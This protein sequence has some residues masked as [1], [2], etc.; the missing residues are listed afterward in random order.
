VFISDRDYE[1]YLKNLESLS[2]ELD[3]RV[4]SYCLM[5]NHVHL[6]VEPVQSGTTLSRMMKVLAA[7][8]TRYVNRLE[9]RTGT[10]WEG[11]FK[12]SIVDSE[13]Y[14]LACMR[15]IDLNPVKAAMVKDPGNY[16]WSSYRVIVCQQALTFLSIHPQ[17]EGLGRGGTDWRNAYEDFVAAGTADSEIEL[18]RTAVARNQLT[19]S[20]RFRDQIARRTGRRIE[21][22]GRGRPK[23]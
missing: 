18:I 21:S 19:G 9:R 20:D 6:L 13:R 22:R 23:K 1:Y 15:Y 8:Q 3:I 12:C 2:T 4:Y 5:S 14:L 10:L 16:R 17:L 7:R 11:R